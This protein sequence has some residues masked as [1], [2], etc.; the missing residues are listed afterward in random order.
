MAAW[1]LE[2][3]THGAWHSKLRCYKPAGKLTRPLVNQGQR[4]PTGMWGSD[5]TFR[6]WSTS[7]PNWLWTIST[8]WNGFFRLIS[9][10]P[11][12]SRS[13]TSSPMAGCAFKR[14]TK[15]KASLWHCRQRWIS[16]SATRPW[17]SHFAIGHNST[18]PNSS[19]RANWVQTNRLQC[20]LTTQSK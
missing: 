12:Y 19:A 9:S 8:L 3:L 16:N 17:Y 5:L 15:F 20:I 18:A 11:T 6:H 2:S 14:D 4:P 1:I 7:T 10:W 13:S